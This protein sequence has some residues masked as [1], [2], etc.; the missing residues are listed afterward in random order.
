MSRLNRVL[1]LLLVAIG[2]PY[3]WFMLD[4]S[5]PK[6]KPVE[7]SVAEF[8]RL[9]TDPDEPGP[10]RIRFEQVARQSVLGN[11]IA[12]GTG[13]RATELYTFSF[14]L[15]YAQGAP[16]LIGGGL[17][18]ADARRYEH[19]NF[20]SAAQ[21]RVTKALSQAR[22]LIPLA[23]VPEQLGALRMLGSSRQAKLLDANLSQQQQA[24]RLGKPHRVAPGVV[25]VPTPKLRPGSRLVFVR[26][27][28]G[29]EY[30]FA[31]SLAPIQES[32]KQMRLPARF[33][34]DIGRTEDRGAIKS[35]L[36]ALRHL[37]REAPALTIVSGNRIPD[38]GG[39]LHYF[40]ESAN[41]R[42]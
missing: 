20:S 25:V 11:R 24:D 33:V 2:A 32:W 40:D 36:R 10:Q 26:L 35:W 5:A 38:R 21:K 7:L 23:P 41:L 34:T 31:G 15:E 18:P 8:R 16:V 19:E 30:L 39:L 1:L 14:L 22:M 6:A 4:N 42:A 17:T 9:A 3:Y 13:L 37:R 29:Q 12:A 27:A 28:N